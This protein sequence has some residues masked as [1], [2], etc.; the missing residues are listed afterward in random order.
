MTLKRGGIYGTSEIAG[1]A[2]LA[3]IVLGIFINARDIV[4]H[5]RISTM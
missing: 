5:I 3:L 4:R 2:V 1:L